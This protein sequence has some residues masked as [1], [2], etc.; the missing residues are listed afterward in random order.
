V[1]FYTNKK[2]SI[3]TLSSLKALKS[4]I[5]YDITIYAS[6]QLLCFLFPLVVCTE[7][8]CKSFKYICVYFMAAHSVFAY[9][10]RKQCRLKYSTRCINFVF[11]HAENT[12]IAE[13]AFLLIYSSD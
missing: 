1:L 6:G 5:I 12:R 9:V 13:L 10:A 8:Q 3:G 2:E 7:Q 11:A 4:S